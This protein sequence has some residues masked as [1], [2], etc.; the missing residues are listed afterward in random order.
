[1]INHLR[2]QRDSARQAERK[3]RRR[4]LASEADWQDWAKQAATRAGN[5]IAAHP[6]ASLGAAVALGLAVGWWVKRR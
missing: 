1:M 5:F 2:K 6:A 4:G 3:G